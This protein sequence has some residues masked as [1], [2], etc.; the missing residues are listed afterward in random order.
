MQATRPPARPQPDLSLDIDLSATLAESRALSQKVTPASGPWDVIV[1]GSGAAGGMAAFQLAT[2]GIKVL[3]LEAGRTLDW[4]KEYRTMEW[5]YQSLRRQRLPPDMRGLNVAEYTFLDRP[6]GNH[7]QFEKFQK[8]T[9]Y[10]GNSFTRNWVVNEKEHPTTGTPYAWV[11]AR[12]LGGKTNFWGRGAL[13]Y[14]P[15]EFKAASH[16]GF[17][18]DWPIGY[19]DVKPYYDKV[20]RLLGCWGPSR[21]SAGCPDGV[22]Q[23]ASKLNCTETVFRNGIATLG[24]KLIPG[25]AGVTTDGLLN[26]KYRQRCMRRGRC[27]RGCDLDASFHSPAA[28]IAPARDTARCVRT[29]W[30]ARCSWTRPRTRHEGSGSSTRRPGRSWTSR[31]AS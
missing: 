17:D 21:A 7:P 5:P 4:Q 24:R 29:R 1:V 15:Y 30:C 2:A 9:S 13:R 22:F 19:E 11:R 8:L 20:N 27:G 14:G 25:R 3:V 10:A 6:Y 28:L 16:D 31:H 12:I 23:T 18:V 26:N